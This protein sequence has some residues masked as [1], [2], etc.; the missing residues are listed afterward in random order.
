MTTLKTNRDRTYNYEYD[1]EGDR[2]H[3]EKIINSPYDLDYEQDTEEWF[4]YMQS[5]PFTEVE[6][7]LD[8][9]KSDESFDAMRYQLTYRRKNGLCASNL[10]KD[11]K[12]NEKCE[13][14]DYLLDKTVENTLVLSDNDDVHIYGEER[15]STENADGTQTYLSGN[16]QSVMAEI[17]SKGT[18][19][20]IEYDDFGKTDDK[21]SGYGYNGEKLDTTGNI[22]LR[23]RYYNPRIGQFVQIDDYKGTQDNITSQNRYTY[24]LNNQ[25]KYVDP[26]GNDFVLGIAII[27]SIMILGSYVL[28][29]L[30]TPA[31][32][33]ANKNLTNVVSNALEKGKKATNN[34]KN[35]IAKKINS[36]KVIQTVTKAIAPAIPVG[37][38]VLKS[39]LTIPQPCPTSVGFDQLPKELLPTIHG[40]AGASAFVNEYLSKLYRV[41]KREKKEKHHIVA[42]KAWDECGRVK[43]DFYLNKPRTAISH[44]LGSLDVEPNYAYISN[45]LHRYIHTRL[46]YGSIYIN[47]QG[48]VEEN[49]KNKRTILIRLGMY[50]KI[51]EGLSDF[52]NKIK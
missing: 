39:T 27:G 3:E 40:L 41:K 33:K 32:R 9:K 10:I 52:A 29:S 13:Y 47:F 12:S 37:I 18:M 48:L 31:L 42:K 17:S 1:G 51:L 44:N 7:L 50:R 15:I 28:G 22:Y 16:N 35:T 5:L 24:C 23:A 46:Y 36:K 45:T 34:L 26:S 20:Q 19:S 25:Y 2:I 8:A 43:H 49:E 38:K 11:P 21:T 6:E 4:D 14:K 30:A